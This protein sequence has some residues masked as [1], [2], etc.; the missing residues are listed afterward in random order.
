MNNIIVALTFILTVNQDVIQ[1]NNYKD[2]GFFGQ[3]LK[4]K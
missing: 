1:I 2:I 4:S 3:N